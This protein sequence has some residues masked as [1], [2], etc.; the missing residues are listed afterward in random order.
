MTRAFFF[1]AVLLLLSVPARA[2]EFQDDLQA[3][4]ARMM[5]QI[6]PDGMLIL[7][8][9]PVRQWSHDVDYEFRQDSNFYYLTGIDQPQSILVLMPG[10][11]ERRE[12]L[13]VSPRDPVREHWEGHLLA[14]SEATAQSGIATVYRTDEFE[15]FINAVLGGSPYRAP[16]REY[17]RFLSALAA[18]H[19]RLELLL[20]PKPGIAGELTAPYVFANKVRERFF[21]FTIADAWPRF[22]RMRQIKT[23]YERAI[24]Q[25]SADVSSEAHMAGMKAAKPGAFEYE[26][27]AA[28]EYTYKKRGAFDWGYPSIVGSGPNATVLHYEKSSRQMADGDLLLVDAAAFYKYMTVDIT[29][30][31]PVSGKFTAAQRDIY[32]IVLDAQ[33][34]GMQVAKAGV[35]VNDVHQKTVDVVKAGLLKL[36]L[37]TDASGDQYRMWYTHGAVHWIGM[38]VHDIG[39][40]DTP[41]APGMAFVIEPGIYIRE[42]VL[43]NLPPTPEN[44]AL[45][46]SLRPAV[47]KYKDIGV[48]VEDSFLMTENGL[49]RLSAK[50]PRTIDEVERFMNT[51]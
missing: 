40:R 14:S 20:T 32:Q 1:V 10:N 8:S 13:F 26:V 22:E 34:Q 5:E 9:A 39:P 3:R 35:R 2:G 29:R 49:V 11:R 21:G 6:S 4:R 36:G 44:Q 17:E 41:L 45:V 42:N 38:D 27:E 12:L 16:A 33:E 50:V 24:L 7:W 46:A 28:I 51:R 31:Y 25:Q 18:G 19:A 43:D 48:R 30:T 23:P 47:Q 37:I 15:A